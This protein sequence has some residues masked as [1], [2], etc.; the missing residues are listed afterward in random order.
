M[1][2]VGGMGTVREIHRESKKERT[3]GI[4]LEKVVKRGNISE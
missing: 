2:G 3:G 4:G 1:G